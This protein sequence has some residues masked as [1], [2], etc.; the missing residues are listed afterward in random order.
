MW[1]CCARATIKT[2][3]TEGGLQGSQK[4]CETGRMEDSSVTTFLGQDHW[5]LGCSQQELLP[6]QWRI[7]QFVT[8]KSQLASCQ[9]V[10]WDPH[11]HI[12]LL[13]WPTMH[14]YTE[15][16]VRKVSHCNITGGILCK[17]FTLNTQSWGY[18]SIILGSMRS[19]KLDMLMESGVFL[20]AASIC[21]IHGNAL[22]YS[23]KH[24]CLPSDADATA[25]KDTCTIAK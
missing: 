6:T 19:F 12:A 4:R 23:N 13:A 8:G 10:G 24:V 22:K 3:K 2:K 16:E 17:A 1:G 21:N 14:W 18:K 9:A 7:K 11:P 25:Q 15:T 5:K 20:R